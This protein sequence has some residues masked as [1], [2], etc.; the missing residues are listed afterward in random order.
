MFEGEWFDVTGEK[1]RATVGESKILLQE[2][3]REKE[4]RSRP[5]QQYTPPICVDAIFSSLDPIFDAVDIVTRQVGELEKGYLVN[6]GD[7]MIFVGCGD[8]GILFVNDVS[9]WYFREV[10]AA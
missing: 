4:R 7:C 5:V 3:R 2:E 8:S 6:F 1:A 10:A 9:R